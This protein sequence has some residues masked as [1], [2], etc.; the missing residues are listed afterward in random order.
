ML[1]FDKVLMQDVIDFKRGS[2]NIYDLQY[3]YTRIA[4]IIRN[5]TKEKINI[6]NMLMDNNQISNEKYNDYYKRVQNDY[7]ISALYVMGFITDLE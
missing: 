4:K 6:L 5:R 7:K 2:D 3:R 1:M